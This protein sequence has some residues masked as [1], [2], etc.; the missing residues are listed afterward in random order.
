[1]TGELINT[2]GIG[3]ALVYIADKIGVT[4]AQMYEIYVHAQQTMAFVQIVFILIWFI[5]VFGVILITH[6]Y[7]KK[8]AS[9]SDEDKVL[10]PITFGAGAA[11]VMFFILIALYFP[12]I[13]YMCPDYTGLKSLMSDIGQIAS[14]IK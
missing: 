9:A 1:M 14:F 4:V 5:V 12:L 10:V 8:D 6:L 3:T 13:A 7:I 2:D 11:I